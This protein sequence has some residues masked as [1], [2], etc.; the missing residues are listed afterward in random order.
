MANNSHRRVNLAP[1]HNEAEYNRCR[2]AAYPDTHK[3]KY[4]SSEA[5]ADYA[6]Y[7]AQ[8]AEYDRSQARYDSQRDRLASQASAARYVDVN[9]LEAREQPALKSM[10]Q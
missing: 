3:P 1:A 5:E 8:H 7:K 6:R 2:Q 9:R 4:P 10:S